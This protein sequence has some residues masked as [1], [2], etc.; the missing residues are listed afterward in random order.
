[1]LSEQ[2]LSW[3]NVILTQTRVLEVCRRIGVARC[4]HI[5]DVPSLQIGQARKTCAP[6]ELRQNVDIFGD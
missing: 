1:M 5:N 6:T 4:R 3:K 2:A